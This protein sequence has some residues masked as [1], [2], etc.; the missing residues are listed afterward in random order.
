[1]AA[2]PA[3]SDFLP[4]VQ[5]GIVSI[6]KTPSQHIFGRHFRKNLEKTDTHY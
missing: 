1:M 5:G 4:V 6:S 2:F 3:V